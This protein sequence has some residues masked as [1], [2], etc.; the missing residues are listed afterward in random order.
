MGFRLTIDDF[1]KVSNRIPYFA[2]LKPSGIYL[3]E[4]LHNAG[5][6]PAVMKYL[7][8]NGLLNGDCIT[9]TGK[10][11]AENLHLLP[12]LTEGQAVIHTLAHPIKEMMVNPFVFF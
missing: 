9:V 12:G 5:G 2:D 7:L 8:S 11:L 1:Q 3:M 4:D 6:T 10:I